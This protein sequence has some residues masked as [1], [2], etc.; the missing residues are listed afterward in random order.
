MKMKKVLTVL[1]LALAVALLVF[2]ATACGEEH[3]HT[4]SAWESVSEPTCTAF[5]IQKRACECG[6]V[7][8]TTVDA[9]A[10]TPVIDAAVSATC[11]TAGRTEGSHCSVCGSIVTAYTEISKL[12]H[13]FGEWKTVVAPTCTSFGIN[14][15]VCTCGELEYATVSATA[16]TPVTDEIVPATCTTPGFTE[17]SHCS[18]CNTVI[19]A[20]TV[21]GKLPHTFG[22][23]K[24]VVAP[25][26]TSIGVNNRVCDCGEVEYATVSALSHTP[27]T[28]KAVA[29]TCTTAGKTEGSHC[30]RCGVIFAAQNDIA[31]IGHKCDDV[32]VIREA[33]C[34]LDGTK[35]YSC[36]NADCEY[37][38]DET[39]ALDEVPAAEIFA[40]AKKYVGT[41]ETYD[42]FGNPL[43]K[44][45]AFVIGSD[46]MIATSYFRI[47]NA[48]SAF[49]T[50]DGVCYDV[51]DV[52]AVSTKSY[53]AILKIDATDLPVAP[54][55]I[56]EPTDGET[57]YTVGVLETDD[58]AISRGIITNAKS[59]DKANYI[60]HDADM[61]YGYLGGPLFNRFGEVIGI[62]AGYEFDG[63]EDVS[64]SAWISE[65]DNLDYSAPMT[66]AEY[67]MATFTLKEYVRFWAASNVNAST[68]TIYAYALR[69]TDFH[70][71]I[72]YDSAK[73]TSFIEGYWKI[74]GVYEVV[75]KIMLGECNGT[76]E[77][78]AGYGDGVNQN[79]IN[80]FIDAATYDKSTVLTYETY[81]GRYWNE[82]ELMAL[83]T[84]K[85]Y[86][87]IGWLSYCVDTYFLDF[88][89]ESFG[90]T[91][92]SY[93]RNEDALAK[94]NEFI[95]TLGAIDESTGMYS[96]SGTAE[97][98]AG[99]LL[100]T[101]SHHPIS[102][103][104]F[105][106]MSY[107][108]NNGVYY[109]LLLQLDPT[110]D[111]GNWYQAH[112]GF[113][114]EGEYYMQSYCWGYVD[115]ANFTNMSTLTCY[116]IAGLGE[117]EDGLLKDY[118][119]LV[120]YILDLL[121]NN[122]MPMIDPALSVKDLGFYF[123]F[124]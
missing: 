22:E 60:M 94:L 68:D 91:A 110:A 43:E 67:G 61:T 100:F 19:V 33:L 27:V 109:R 2:G 18:D 108:L 40:N 113:V 50:L 58:Y 124:G 49:F 82:D 107:Y 90:F 36:T 81:H 29:A 32:T 38:Y 115:A 105:V 39:Y 84:E 88:T 45:T 7:E 85:V 122:V 8:Y 10:H 4:F 117:Y 87:T 1:A 76:Y 16:H 83:Y 79:E 12:P 34:N 11:T 37:Y 31:P 56:G 77:Y 93:D 51:T 123:Y 69:G 17:G 106:D 59:V 28:D 72:G 44:A 42:K 89:M 25:T 74:Q 52:L 23:W 9:I 104:T 6:E 64:Y 30:S 114:E 78:F 47:D 112:Y 35:R 55:C 24:T 63:E 26:C 66:I 46:G 111:L 57:V 71:A 13:T 53:I 62:N 70:Y 86:A 92:L 96:L 120:G 73:N 14:N 20:Q 119:M 97:Q 21:I 101:L 75:V 5:G 95:M 98:S 15:R 116:Y 121:N 99:V 65:L 48:S 80:G 41:I 54:L 103:T 3:E 118:S 102:N